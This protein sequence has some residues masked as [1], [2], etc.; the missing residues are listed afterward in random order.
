[1]PVF[2]NVFKL[3]AGSIYYGAQYFSRKNAERSV[4][5]SSGKLV[6]RIRIKSKLHRP[7]NFL[8]LA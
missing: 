6:Y 5:E 7:V 4:M 2:V 3:E 8:T 1:M